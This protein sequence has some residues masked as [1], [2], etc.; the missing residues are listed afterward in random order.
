MKDK[1][2]ERQRT[3]IVSLV[4]SFDGLLLWVGTSSVFKVIQDVDKQEQ[5]T[6]FPRLLEVYRQNHISVLADS[7]N[8]RSK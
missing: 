3:E 5:I 8:R 2:R 4:G 1:G 7:W 6:Y